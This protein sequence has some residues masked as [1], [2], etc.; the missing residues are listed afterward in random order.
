M[1]HGRDR[2][3]PPASAHLLNLA[4]IF[5]SAEAVA[6]DGSQTAAGTWYRWLEANLP[7]E[8][9]TS[10]EWPVSRW[11]IQALLALRA[12]DEHGAK[13]DFER[14]AT[15]AAAAQYPVELAAAQLQLSELLRHRGAAER[16]WKALR[17]GG[18]EALRACGLD[19]AVFAYAVARTAPAAGRR[20]L[21]SRLT[22][23]ETDVVV[24]LAEGLTYRQ[25]GDALGV[26][27]TTVQTLAHR[28][29]EKLEVSGRQAAVA[30]ARELGIL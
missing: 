12:G 29:Y 20:G 7:D 19:P 8:V 18:S 10:L 21:T 30:K 22:P 13:R 26:K 27:W 2:L 11:R 24:R 16:T 17:E 6:L 15:W 14:A 9:V 3:R 25:I 5:A 1:D 4:S 23:R 28:C